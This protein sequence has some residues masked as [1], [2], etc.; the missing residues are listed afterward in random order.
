MV[1]T[2]AGFVETRF[3]GEKEKKGAEVEIQPNKPTTISWSSSLSVAAVVGW[4]LT[5]LLLLQGAVAYLFNFFF[6]LSFR[7]VF[8]A[9]NKWGGGGGSCFNILSE[10]AA[11]AVV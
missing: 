5:Q 4:W 3:R 6:A 9:P 11:A 8:P 1:S 2:V 7:L 10:T